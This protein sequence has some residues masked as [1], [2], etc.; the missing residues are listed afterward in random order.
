MNTITE[1]QLNQGLNQCDK[2]EVITISQDLI[3]INAE[4][5]TPYENEK[6]SEKTHRQYEALCE[7]CYQSELI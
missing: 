7:D 3:W 6:L 4:D 5:F 2:C 1:E